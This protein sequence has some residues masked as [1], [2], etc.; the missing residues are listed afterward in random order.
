MRMS[1]LLEHVAHTMTKR[2][3]N[4]SELDEYLAH[5]KIEC[6]ECGKFFSFLPNHIIKI[7][8]MSVSVYRDKFNI[9]AMAPLA[10]VLYRQKHREKLQ[11]IVDEGKI[12]YSHLSTAT[13]LA[14]GSERTQRRDFD[15]VEQSERASNI[16]HDTLPA[17]AK[18][19]DG[20]DAVKT[21]EYQR[22]HRAMKKRIRDKIN[23]L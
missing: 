19:A 14:I 6:L 5:D 23:K 4:R 22:S 12:N 7:H 16:E 1:G 21:R 17:G 10:G 18:R 15:L 2:I 3:N 9:P 8:R 13:K 20:K 11:R